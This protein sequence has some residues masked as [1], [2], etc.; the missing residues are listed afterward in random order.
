MSCTKFACDA[1][2]LCGDINSNIATTPSSTSARSDCLSATTANARASRATSSPTHRAAASVSA[3]LINRGRGA[4]GRP[5]T[6]RS[7][8]TGS[9]PRRRNTRAVLRCSSGMPTTRRF[10]TT[11]SITCRTRACQSAGAAGSSDSPTAIHWPTTRTTTWSRTT[12]S[13]TR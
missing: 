2:F 12:S 8:T 1:K 7:R 6:S 11:R 3:V 4:R 5:H 9:T 10:A 13:S